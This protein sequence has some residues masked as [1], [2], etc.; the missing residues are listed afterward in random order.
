VPTCTLERLPLQRIYKWRC[1]SL[2]HVMLLMIMS[3][4]VAQQ[5]TC[6]TQ[7]YC[8]GYSREGI[9]GRGHE[10]ISTKECKE[11]KGKGTTTEPNNANNETVQNQTTGN[12][13]QQRDYSESNRK[14]NFTSNSTSSPDPHDTQT[15]RRIHATNQAY[16]PSERPPVLRKATV[17]G[18]L[19]WFTYLE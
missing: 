12:M 1:C 8:V 5:S 11:T 10:A 7:G 15:S 16:Q 2:M 6:C 13:P 4:K 3:E 9:C 14:Y 19:L 18:C 17:W